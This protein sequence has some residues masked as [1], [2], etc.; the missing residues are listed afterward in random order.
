MRNK[1]LFFALIISTLFS[2]QG[3]TKNLPASNYDS[4]EVG[5][6]NKVASGTVVSVQAINIR[7]KADANG[8]DVPPNTG[9]PMR[10]H[11]YEY[12]IKLNSGAII[13]IAQTEGVPMNPKQ[14]VLVIYG[15]TTR[16]VPDEGSDEF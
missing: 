16:V 6:I 9:E 12:V 14:H 1:T 15:N 8:T 3:C 5:K 10:S 13:S 2:L 4:T 11:G 7:N